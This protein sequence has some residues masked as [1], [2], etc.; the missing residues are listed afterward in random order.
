LKSDEISLAKAKTDFN[1]AKKEEFYPEIKADLARGRSKKTQWLGD[2]ELKEYKQTTKIKEKPTLEINSEIARPHPLGGKLKLNLKVSE[3]FKTESKDS[4]ELKLESEEPVSGYRRNNLKDPLYEQKLQLQIAHLNQEEK[5]NG[6][7][8]KVIH[9]YSG[10]KKLDSQLVI[11]QKELEDLQNNLEISKFKLEKGL[12][13]EMDIFQMELQISSV[14]IEIEGL[15]KEKRKGLEEFYYILGTQ[16]LQ[17]QQVD[18][19]KGNDL[20]DKIKGLKEWISNYFRFSIFDFRFVD[21]QIQTWVENS[22]I[23]TIKKQ[24]VE[25]ELAKRKLKDAQTK[26]IPTIIPSFTV[27]KDKGQKE[28]AFRVAVNLP[29]YDKG[30]KK[31]EIKSAQASLSQAEIELTNLKWNLQ[32]EIKGLCDEIENMERRIEIEEKNL[33]L[34]E[35]IYEIAK[36]KHQRGLISAKDLLEYQMQL[37][38]KQK[39]LFEEQIEIFLKI[40]EILKTVGGLSHAFMEKII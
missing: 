31:E 30:I 4:W 24:Q 14:L 18:G 38:Q 35:E 34:A 1:K 40:I 10:L 8:Y 37:F 2:E 36:I 39:H 17:K 16:T 28:E 9:A 20:Q 7:I 29:V 15:K 25:L 3:V 5:I 6:I 21:K 32:I 12:I 11:K 19:D 27:N 33:K 22:Q 26:N 23:P 13:P